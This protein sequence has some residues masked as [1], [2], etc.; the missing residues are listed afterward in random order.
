VTDAHRSAVLAALQGGLIVSC[1]PVP[2]GPMDNDDMVLALALAG[3]AGGAVAVRIEGVA[4]VARVAR[5]LHIPVIGI[6]KRGLPHSPVRITPG[7]ADVHALAAAGARWIATDATHRTRPDPLPDLLQAIHAHGCLAMADCA[8]L[9]EGLAAH[10]MGFDVVGTTLSGYTEDTLCASDAAPD[11]ALV[12]ALHAAGVWTIAEGRIA[13][14]AL[15][16]KALACG[17]NAVTVGSALTRL[18][19]MVGAYVQTMKQAQENR[20]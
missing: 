2:G 10:N 18:E 19:W 5:Q 1:Q 17:A 16:A 14:A 13:N 11:L 3:Q 9:Q 4:R 6:V 7:L 20:P 8:T 15:A 12:Q